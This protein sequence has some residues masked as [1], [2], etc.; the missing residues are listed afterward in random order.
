MPFGLAELV[1]DL[2]HLNFTSW[3]PSKLGR[4]KAGYIGERRSRH[5]SLPR[6]TDRAAAADIQHSPGLRTSVADN[7][8]GDRTG[9]L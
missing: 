8:A 4:R 6:H 9:R 1:L 5:E 2:T 3:Y 7:R